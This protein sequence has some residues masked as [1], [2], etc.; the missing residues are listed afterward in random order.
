M[1]PALYNMINERHTAPLWVWVSSQMSCECE[2]LYSLSAMIPPLSPAPKR[3]PGDA[4]GSGSGQ[5]RR[6]S[7]CLFYQDLYFFVAVYFICLY[8]SNS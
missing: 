7:S 8:I 2:A 3:V 5:G 1:A 6:V 4:V